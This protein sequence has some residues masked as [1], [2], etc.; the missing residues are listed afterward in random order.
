M[1]HTELVERW[2][3]QQAAYIA[4]REARFEVMLG[5]LELAVGTSFTAVDLACGP[6]SLASRLLSRFPEARVIAIDYDPMLLA[7]ARKHLA[8][9]GDRVQIVDAD[10]VDPLWSAQL[11]DQLEDRPQAVVSTTA[12][13][14]L[15]PA[16][17]V[18]VYGQVRSL[19]ARG[20]LLLNGDHFRFDE[21]T[22][23]IASWA[24]RHDSATQK[25]SFVEGA[26]EWDAW[27]NLLGAHPDIGPLQGERT[28]RFAGRDASP[29]TTVKFQLAA[30]RQ[31]GFAE[32]GT[33]WQLFDD[34]VVYGVA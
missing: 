29:P 30:L 9:F 1:N 12:L 34:Y 18:D 32:S 33:V 23:H 28:R 6:G 22:Q 19:L 11:R 13:H 7:L 27:W 3:R 10:L 21:R 16:Q 24:A 26:D 15:L 2:D 25:R 4:H 31:A 17:L 14:W 20:G 5:A 8:G